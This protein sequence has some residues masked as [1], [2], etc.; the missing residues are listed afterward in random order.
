MVVSVAIYPMDVDLYQ[1]QK[2]LDNGKLAL[3][4][5]G[6]LIM[7]SKCRTGIGE[8]TFFG[9]LASSKNPREVLERIDRGYKLG[10]HK[11][12]K[13]AQIGTWASIYGVT[14]LPDEIM[15]KAHLK[16]F[17]SVQEALDTAIKEMREKGREPS[18]V[19]M[20]AGSLTIPLVRS[21]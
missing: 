4:E 16:P 21:D 19:I 10:Y 12:A 5:G 1:S 17:G 11:A 6:I 15:K 8:R 13:M 9:L 18:L 3:R 20:P 7:V 14:D 2:A